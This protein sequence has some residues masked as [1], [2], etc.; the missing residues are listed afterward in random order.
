MKQSIILIGGGGHCKACIDILETTDMYNIE[1][2]LD[3]TE[4]TGKNILGYSIIGTDAE[5]KRL[6]A[7]N[8]SFLITVG[9]IKSSNI[10]RNIFD[11]LKECNA[12][13]ATII[14]TRAYVSNHAKIGEGT[15]VMDAVHVN[16]G[17]VIGSNSILN[18]GSCVEHNTVIGNHCHISTHAVVNGDCVI[19]DDVFIG[20][21]SVI[22]QGVSICSGSVIGAG[23]VVHASIEEPGLYAG[24]PFKKIG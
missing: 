11:K 18:T 2:I 13:I 14:S 16:A 23:T 22:V 1:G 7:A 21:N 6:S 5:I 4:N 10:R 8:N 24:N 3:V 9:Q 12:F 20:S 15:I 19:N 17:A